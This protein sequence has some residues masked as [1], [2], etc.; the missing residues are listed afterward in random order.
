[1]RKLWSTGETT[2]TRGRRDASGRWRRPWLHGENAGER[3]SGELERLGANQEVSRI[4]GEGA[5]LTETTNTTDA[6]RRPW[7]DGEPSVEFHERVH[8]AIER[9]RE[10]S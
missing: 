2:G 6:R 1:M 4:A 5:E 10:F 9:A 7:N 8:R 3:G